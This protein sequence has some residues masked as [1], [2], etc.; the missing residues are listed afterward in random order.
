[1]PISRR[2]FILGS[3]AAAA[4]GGLALH[5]LRPARKPAFRPVA[6]VAAER[7]RYDDFSD[8]W[9]EK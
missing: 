3:A 8:L 6:P 2:R 7:V 4:T 9:R 5:Y 1:M